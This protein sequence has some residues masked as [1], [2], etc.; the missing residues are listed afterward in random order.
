MSCESMRLCSGKIFS[1]VRVPILIVIGCRHP[2]ITNVSSILPVQILKLPCLRV[3]HSFDQYP[4]ISEEAKAA[5]QDNLGESL[6]NGNK[7]WD[8]WWGEGAVPGAEGA[9][10]S[11][12]NTGCICEADSCLDA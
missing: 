5:F 10:G 12:L 9:G 6:M 1:S 7:V 11:P 8:A 3:F 4:V 2:I